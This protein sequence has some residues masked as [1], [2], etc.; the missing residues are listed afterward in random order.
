[1]PKQLSK[2]PIVRAGCPSVGKAIFHQQLE[3]QVRI[4]TIR[5]LLP[6]PLPSN[7]DWVTN[8]K[9]ESKFRHESLEPA[10]AARSLHAHA[11]TDSA[12][13][14]FTIKL[15]HL[16]FVMV[17][18]AFSGL[19]SFEIDK[20]NFLNARVIVQTHNQHIRVLAP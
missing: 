14:Q 6:Y 7:L 1:M 5:L 4:S 19:S 11:H 16:A 20:R 13:L 9:F 10:C 3:Q 12:L 8:P 18:L 2:I 17:K 15:L